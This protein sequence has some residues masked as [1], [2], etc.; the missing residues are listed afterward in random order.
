ME[1]IFKKQ[2]FLF[3]SDASWLNITISKKIL[4]YCNA[5]SVNFSFL[6]KNDLKNITWKY[7]EN[8][9][10]IPYADKN[11]KVAIPIIEITENDNIY[12]YISS[13]SLI[14]DEEIICGE[15]I[16]SLCNV[17]I[18]TSEKLNCNPNNKYFSKKMEPIEKNPNIQ[19]YK[20]IFV[21]TDNIKNFYNKYAQNEDLSNK[22]IITHNSDHEIDNSFI[23]FLNR[24]EK[25]FSQNC[26]IQ[27]PKLITL[28]IGIENR[29]WF[30]HQILHNVRKRTDI[31]KT[32][33]VYFFFSFETHPSRHEQYEQLK[34]KLKWNTKRSKEDYFIELKRHKYA[35]CPRG[36]GL[37]THRL[38]ECFYLDVIPIMISKDF[39][40]VSNLP[41]LVFHSWNDFNK[42]R[43]TNLFGNIHNSKIT[44]SYY[45]K[46]L[47]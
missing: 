16:Q 27:H 32:E 36:N 40:N 17:V 42:Y 35:I 22:K 33:D 38:W 25:Q 34:N 19:P 5:S 47:N 1:E 6:R 31:K 37:D 28:P 11:G 39:V 45:K 30:N 20:N 12:D 44:M 8:N 10:R 3:N 29:Q 18:G 9:L 15:N 43:L 26:L 21:F 24:V 41:I 13:N 14:P 2:Y 7:N 46:L 4:I 23:P